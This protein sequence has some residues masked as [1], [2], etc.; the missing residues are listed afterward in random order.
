M[1]SN[2]YILFCPI[3]LSSTF[4][5]QPHQLYF[6]VCCYIPIFDRSLFSFHIQALVL[7]IFTTMDPQASL[8]PTVHT[9]AAPLPA[10]AQ[11]DLHPEPSAN[12]LSKRP[13]ST[14]GASNDG[15]QQRPRPAPGSAAGPIHQSPMTES[16]GTADEARDF[17]RQTIRQIIL[18]DAGQAASSSFPQALPVLPTQPPAPRA[19]PP[20]A[21]APGPSPAPTGGS[22]AASPS[23]L[24]ALL[25]SLQPAGAPQGIIPAPSAVDVQGACPTIIDTRHNFQSVKGLFRPELQPIMQS[26]DFLRERLTVQPESKDALKILETLIADTTKQSLLEQ[27]VGFNPETGRYISSIQDASKYLAAHGAAGISI[28][29]MKEAHALNTVVE[30]MCKP[31]GSVRSP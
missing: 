15:R 8:V 27:T 9:P 18:E 16:P 14:S 21:K 4:Q 13:A 28:G 23:S 7:S 25:L 10:G 1:S 2:F 11:V 6:P 20:Q 24:D 26:L 31:P 22:A 29:D 19:G 30:R 5:N 3:C 17:I 12:A